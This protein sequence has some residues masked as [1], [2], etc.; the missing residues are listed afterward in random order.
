MAGFDD[1]PLAPQQ[2]QQDPWAAFP[3]EGQPA[4]RQVPPQTAAPSAV[5]AQA[6]FAAP[7]PAELADGSSNWNAT[8][9]REEQ[10]WLSY[11]YDTLNIG[12]DKILRGATNTVGLPVDAINAAPMLANIIPGVDGVGPMSGYPIGGS[13]SLYDAVTLGGLFGAPEPKDPFQRIVARTGEELG[14]AA[15]PAAGLLAAG[16]RMGVQG[17]REA[18]P[19][20]RNFVEP[21]AVNPLNF[22]TKEAF[23]AGAAGMGAG[24]ANELLG[25]QDRSNPWIDILGAF[26][27][28]GL[29]GTG[30]AVGRSLVDLGAAATGSERYA[31]QIVRDR[32]ADE[33]SR[34]SSVLGQQ[35]DAA[36]PGQPID[37]QALIDLINRPSAAETAV[38]GF[39]ATT[40]DRAA[41]PGL[42]A[43]ESARSRSNPGAFR[44]RQDANT[45]AVEGAMSG[46]APTETP[47]AFRGALEDQRGIVLNEASAA[48]DAADTAYAQAVA[49]LTPLMTGE[50]RGADIRAAL[51]G[52]SDSAKAI[53]AEAWKPVNEANVPVNIA[54]LRDAFAQADSAVPEALQPLIPGASAVPDRLAATSETQ[55]VAEV[56]GIRTALSNDLRRAGITPQETR[57]IEERIARLDAYIEQTLPTALRDQYSTARS[58]TRDY[59]DR[60]TRPNTAIGQTLRTT[61]G[62]GY[63]TPD[64]GVAR[65]FAQPDQGRLSDTDALFREAGNDPRA[66]EAF[67]DQ[68]RQDAKDRG[69]L[70]S[71]EAARSFVANN[72]KALERVPELRDQINAVGAAKANADSALRVES[73]LMTQLTKPGRSAVANYLSF[74]DEKAVTAMRQ[75]AASRDPAKAADELLNFVGNDPKAVEGARAA[76]W[77]HMDTSVRAKNAAAE[78]D[79]GTMPIVP[80]KMAAFLDDPA[81]AAVAE[82][83]Y[84]DNPQHLTDIRALAESLR[85]TNTGA[86][87]GNAINPSGTALMLRGQAPVTMA[88]LGSK[89]YQMQLGR[90]SPAYLAAHIAGKISAKAVGSQRA[91]AFDALLDQALLD[92]ETASRLLAK[93]NPANRAA[94]ARRLNLWRFN[95]ASTVLRMLEEDEE[96][97]TTRAIMGD[98]Q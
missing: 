33:L 48:R 1:F 2:P 11:L 14:A 68:L 90:V 56:M 95:E 45:Q 17:A 62:G 89:F 39:Q 67:A 28:V 51:E 16:S 79:S 94:L 73:D 92:P 6:G 65:R 77:K 5:P 58:A 53:V 3:V 35:V 4:Q 76:F 61:E 32:V 38:P 47:G 64:S 66:K 27:G 10:S 84:R 26:G 9:P 12:S 86:R 91:K 25:N 42:A 43:L 75:V 19:L 57:L 74:G 80:R 22:A 29:A 63:Q 83:L 85:G 21:A 52:A 23:A 24:A 69:A 81:N 54:P 36:K 34:N 20:L 87:I 98:G 8:P 59:H 37:T 70:T 44:A 31:G 60:F 71:P 15:V 41:D 55:P 13:Q 7:P 93:N 82:R 50:A 72:A 18:G 97:P 30:A 78:T 96:D 49:P 88:E 40:A 46:L